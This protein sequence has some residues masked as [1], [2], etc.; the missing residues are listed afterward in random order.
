MPPQRKHVERLWVAITLAW[1]LF[2]ALV[3]WAALSRYGVNPW[4]YLTIE[5]VS[6]GPYGLAT[7]RIVTSLLDHRRDTAFRWAI[8]AAVLFLAPD[9]YIVAAGRSMPL[10]VYVVV[11][12]IVA[13]LGV[14]GILRI[15]VAVRAARERAILPRT[16]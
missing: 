14:A 9:L 10:Y 15:R 1:G 8:A 7:A 16:R 5:L 6:S 13:A 3:V 4:I 2:R 12:V 11:G